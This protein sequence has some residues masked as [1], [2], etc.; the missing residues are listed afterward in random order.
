M[1]TTLLTA[2]FSQPVFFSRDDDTDMF[3]LAPIS[4]WAEDHSALKRLFDEWRQEGVTD[5][6]A[7]LQADPERVERGA[8]S[9]RVLKIN[10]RTLSLYG[11]ADLPELIDNL[12]KIIRD[13]S[14]PAFIEEMVQ[15]WNG[16]TSFS[17]K[18]V[19][20]SLSNR[21]IDVRLNGHI[22]PG[23]ESDW[24]RVL[25]SVEDITAEEEAHRRLVCAEQEARSLFEESPASLWIGDFSVIK[26]LLDEVRD[27]GITDLRAFMETHPE[28]IERCIAEVKVIDINRYTLTLFDALDKQ[29]L[30]GRLSGIIRNDVLPEFTERLIDLWQGKLRQER[31]LIIH[32][33]KGEALNLVQQFSVMP[34]HEHNWSRVLFAL[35]DITAQKKAEASL[36]YLSNHDALTGLYNRSFYDKEVARLHCK[37]P[38]PFSVIILDLDGLKSVNDTFG[39]FA[40]DALIRRAGEILSQAV[41]KSSHPIR[42]GGDEFVVLMPGATAAEVDMLIE[43]INALTE[44]SNRSHSSGTLHWSLGYATCKASE[45]LEETIKE[46]DRRMYKAKQKYY[47]ATTGLERRR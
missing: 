41:D 33:L 17:F 5:L 37:G 10:R 25:I 7:S 26:K 2:D 35:T 47:E 3:D 18:S 38:F 23:Y 45:P 1:K 44:Q 34:N 32:T 39:H 21:R 29:S 36:E 14:L 43:R 24:S 6:R 40:G 13:D 9:I 28:F 12:D 16:Q 31:E 42:I 4:L 27:R 15:F 8:R 22:L 20:Y 30:L 19:N 46:A 11:V